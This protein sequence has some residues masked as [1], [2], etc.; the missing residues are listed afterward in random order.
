MVSVGRQPP[1]LEPPVAPWVQGKCMGERL[2]TRSGRDSRAGGSCGSED[3]KRRWRQSY[4][5]AE[6]EAVQFVEHERGAAAA[7][8]EAQKA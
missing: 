2:P 4:S 7:S 3:A 6:R 5:F 8:K 1:Q